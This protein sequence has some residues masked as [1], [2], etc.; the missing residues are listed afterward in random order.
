VKFLTRKPRFLCERVRDVG[1]DVGEKNAPGAWRALPD[2]GAKDAV[3]ST[4]KEPR[5]EHFD[6]FGGT[7]NVGRFD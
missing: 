1:E 2:R 5:T 7:R 3:E 4:V 6:A